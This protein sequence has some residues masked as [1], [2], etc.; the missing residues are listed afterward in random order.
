MLTSTF[1]ASTENFSDVLEEIESV[2]PDVVIVV[3]RVRNDLNIARQLVSSGLG[4]GVVVAVAAGIQQFH[5]HLGSLADGF[6]G[7]SQ[8]EQGL[9]FVPDFGPSPEQVVT[10]LKNG[11]SQ[12]IDY[13]MVQAYA[14]G[15]IV[16]RCFMEASSCGSPELRKV[17][18]DLKFS[19]FYGNFE[20]DAQTG[21][22]V[23]RE[24]LLVQ[25]QL[26]KKTIVW[27]PEQASAALVYPW[28]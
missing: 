14:V 12:H 18:A 23:G 3:G 7:P 27:P 6:V 19:T 25:W 4:A 24:T 28:R 20:I 15:L 26:G 9:D 13:P 1:A 11:A 5:D 16:E 22:Q 8:W 2:H 17:A 10:S 21:R